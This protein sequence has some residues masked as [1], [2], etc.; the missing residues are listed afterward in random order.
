MGGLQFILPNWRPKGDENYWNVSGT[1]QFILV[2]GPPAPLDRVPRSSRRSL[3][4]TKESGVGE[5]GRNMVC[6]GPGSGPAFVARGAD[7]VM[8][9]VNEHHI[10]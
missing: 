6:S 2:V 9:T 10:T 8:D 1:Y 7:A 4:E 5:K 3:G